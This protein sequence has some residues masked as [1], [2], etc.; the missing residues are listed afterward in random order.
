MCDLELL[1]NG[2]FSPL[3]GFMGSADHREVCDRM[4]LADGTLWPIPVT[5]DIPEAL[6]SRLSVGAKLSLRDPEGVMLSALDVDE[7]W[8]PDWETEA[9]SVFGTLEHSHPGVSYLVHRTH[10]WRVGGRVRGL[11]LP[12]HYDF[13]SL[14]QSPSEVRAAFAKLG[15]ERVVAFNTRNPMHRVHYE[16]TLRAIRDYDVKLLIHPV[17]GMTKSGDIDH[18]TRVRCYQAML[19]HYPPNT[20]MLALLPLAMRM[21]GPREALLHA[22]VRKNYGCSHLIVGRD[23][24]GPGVNAQGQPFYDVFASQ[25]LAR[26]HSQELGITIVPFPVMV[27][28][29]ELDHYVPEAEVPQGAT[30]V[31]ISG[32][33]LRRRLA[34]GRDVPPWFTFP[35]IASILRETHP[36]RSH[37]GFT[38]FFT[39]LSGAGKSTIA[40]ILMARL[41]ERGGRRVTL[42]DGDVLRK[43]LSKDL[44]F[45]KAD[46]DAHI[47]RVAYVAAEITK[48]GG[49]AICAPIAPYEA[50]RQEAR[51]TV[52]AFG[53]FILVYVKTPLDVCEARDRKGLYAKAR[54]GLIENFTGI[55]DPY[56]PPSDPD[57]AISTNDL[58]AKLAA[59]EVIRFLESE[60]YLEGLE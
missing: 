39:G 34:D 46:R 18:T 1:L 7:V 54:A 10:R 55:S 35:E 56:E 15:W 8:Q 26:Q 2:G 37:R 27:Y 43:V 5:L 9:E 44:D 17:V 58:S 29:K 51:R 42:L 3:S 36:V 47:R 28:V 23:H 32:T 30:P 45:S 19:R 21:A 12:T 25:R 57:V 60:G 22:I 24:A 52:E 14:R 4:R 53:G 38:V 16:L 41:L 33:E 49:V 59:E 13:L 11:Q 6:A 20:A 40:N 31:S 50:A 48:H